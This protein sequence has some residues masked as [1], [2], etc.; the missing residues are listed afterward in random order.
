MTNIRTIKLPIN[1]SE[2]EKDFVKELQKIQ[3][4]MVRCSYNASKKGLKEKDIRPILKERFQGSSLDSWF[5]Q[6]SIYEGRAMFAADQET[7][8]ES[9][10]FGGKGNSIKRAKN[11][12]TKEQWKDCRLL[13]L[14]LIGEAPTKGN[15]KFDFCKD[16]IVFKPFKNKKI[17]IA[18]PDL[19]NKYK[20]LWHKAV[21]M[22]EDKKIPITVKLTST[23]IFLTFNFD[24]LKEREHKVIKDRYCGIDVNPNF[25]GVTVF[26]GS[27][28]ISN[29]LF[30]LKSLT[31]KGV[32][33]NKLKHETV[34]ITHQIKNYLKHF[35]V[36]KVFVEDLNIKSKN[37]LKGKNYNR[38]VNNQWKRNCFFS[39][40]GKFFNLFYL[41]AAYSSTIGNVLHKDLPDPLASSAEIAQRGFRLIITKNKQ[42]YPEL[43]SKT[44]L[45]ELWK[46]TE[47][48]EVKDWKELHYWLKN[49]KVKY[50][51]SVPKETVFRKFKSKN[52]KVDLALDSFR[53]TTFN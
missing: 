49:S 8:N 52:S 46:Q 6:S 2:E 27:R 44:C 48:P 53:M 4:S 42:F 29:Q 13:P 33:E 34:E 41:N 35:Q 39:V 32:N 30:D 12:I 24:I 36:D 14:V 11:L 50:R 23:E 21:E 40:L 10:I 43:P 45:E 19:K 22:S 17:E 47:V 18:L 26:Q 25:I 5:Q 38:L 28:M 31:G 51:V 1:L 15:R 9:R 7:G 3:S 20:K 37:N 16:K